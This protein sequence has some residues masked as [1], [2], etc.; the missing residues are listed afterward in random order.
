MSLQNL[1]K[2]T[3][4]LNGWAC[5]SAC[6]LI[7]T[8]CGDQSGIR[9]YEVP[10]EPVRASTAVPP[11]AMSGSDNAAWFFK[12]TGPD[13]T[14]LA[15]LKSFTDIIR[16][17][18]FESGV[19]DYDVPEGWESKSGPA[20]RYQT[21]TIPETDPPLEVAISS[22]PVPSSSGMSSYLKANVDRWRGQLGLDPMTG[23]DWLE[24]AE[25]AG[26][27][28]KFADESREVT[29]VNLEGATETFGKTRMFAAILMTSSP[30][31]APPPR[32]TS[33][34]ASSPRSPLKYNLPEGWET[35]TGSSMRA[36][37]FRISG[38][39]GEIDVSVM[40]LGGGGDMLPNVNRWRGQVKLEPI[41]AADLEQ[42]LT[43]IEVAGQP[44]S[45]AEILGE[46]EGIVVAT[47]PDGTAK[48][49]YKMQGPVDMIREETERFREFL[50][51][52]SFE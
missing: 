33:P 19:P 37:S 18:R 1:R 11:A 22:L 17:V 14:I 21:L 16:S 30:S 35:S 26:E 3:G 8:S 42:H 4:V 43:P 25:I 6:C 20:P 34:S 31:S 39:G 45:L 5:L 46:A 49:F 36:A 29:I 9:Q 40:K 15:H 44:G 41:S 47:V 50:T 10:K 27:I 51:S 23:P 38:E 52:V 28:T 2:R 13:E 7:L 48:W 12:L 32:T 24:Q